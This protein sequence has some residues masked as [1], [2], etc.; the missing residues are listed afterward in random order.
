[1]HK[2]LSSGTSQFVRA[3][4]MRSAGANRDALPVT[5]G[6]GEGT[7]QMHSGADGSGA[8]KGERTG[9]Y[10]RG[11][12]CRTDCRTLAAIVPPTSYSSS[13]N[14][15]AVNGRSNGCLNVKNRSA[16]S[17]ARSLAPPR[18]RVRQRSTAVSH[19]AKSPDNVGGVKR[20][21]CLRLDFRRSCERSTRGPHQ[22][23]PG[24]RTGIDRPIARVQ[25]P[26]PFQERDDVTSL[27]KDAL[28]DPAECRRRDCALLRGS[29]STPHAGQPPRQPNIKSLL[30][31]SKPSL[32]PL[33]DPQRDR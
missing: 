27:V 15:I 3:A 14:A 18:L 20:R 5:S 9:A 26:P 31:P 2:A 4:E 11:R 19:A 24:R 23:R 12:Y 8:P 30:Q 28:A 33:F 22:L 21:S 25:L 17:R 7:L 29:W 10:K 6:S 1:M 32:S 13:A 16:M